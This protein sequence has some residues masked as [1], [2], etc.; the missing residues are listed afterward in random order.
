M[1][2]KVYII[3]ILTIILMITSIESLK[4]I[5]KNYYLKKESLNDKE[6]YD[7]FTNKITDINQ[8]INNELSGYIY[9]GRDTCP[10]CLKFNEFLKEEYIQKEDLLI[11]K[12]DTDYWR[13]DENFTTVL[14][15]YK[16]SSIPTLI[17]INNDKSYETLEFNNNNENDI[18]ST[19]HCFLYKNQIN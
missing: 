16:I 8:L 18:E 9:F 15:N 6:V 10:N 11:Y 19:L 3:L 13:N 17:L 14:D 4:I 12:F 1:K 2:K 5:S 7:S